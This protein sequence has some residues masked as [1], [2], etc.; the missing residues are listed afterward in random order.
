M[1][2]LDLELVVWCLQVIDQQELLDEYCLLIVDALISRKAFVMCLVLSMIVDKYQL[3]G[4][5][6]IFE[7]HIS[8]LE[9]MRSFNRKSF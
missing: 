9:E 3:K 5:E 1:S 8:N 2:S 7:Q 6:E 4:R